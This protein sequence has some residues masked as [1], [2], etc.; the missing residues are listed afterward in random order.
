MNLVCFTAKAHRLIPSPRTVLCLSQR[1]QIHFLQCSSKLHKVLSAQLHD[2]YQSQSH[3]QTYRHNSRGWPSL[4]KD[5]RSSYQ[6]NGINLHQKF[7]TQAIDLWKLTNPSSYGGIRQSI[8]IDTK[9]NTHHNLNRAHITTCN[10]HID[11]YTLS[12]RIG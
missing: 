6:L 1:V 7:P 2:V 3:S 8:H 10:T 12:F 4:A 5:Y 11:I 9:Y